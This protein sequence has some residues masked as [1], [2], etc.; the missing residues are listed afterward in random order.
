MRRDS[1]RAARS[2]L[3][4]HQLSLSPASPHAAPQP[5]LPRSSLEPRPRAIPPSPSGHTP[6]L[7]SAAAQRSVSVAPRTA[8]RRV[9]PRCPVNPFDHRPSAG[10]GVFRDFFAN[11]YRTT[12]RR[13]AAVTLPLSDTST[14]TSRSAAGALCGSKLVSQGTPEIRPASWGTLV[15]EPAAIPARCTVVGK[16]VCYFGDCPLLPARRLRPP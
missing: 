14:P 3:L 1:P 15:A 7:C 11:T 2:K 10:R 16:P 6:R 8:S 13:S 5:F 4:V 9:S 12:T